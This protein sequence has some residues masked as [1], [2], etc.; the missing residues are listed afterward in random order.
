MMN[1][2]EI[3]TMR[4]KVL[5]ADHHTMLR[6]ALRV[7][8]EREPDIKVIA[9]ESNGAR[10]LQAAR[11]LRP[12]VVVMDVTMPGM[13]G[14]HAVQNLVRLRLGIKFIALATQIDAIHIVQ[15]LNAGANGYVINTSR[16]DEM[17]SAIR[18]VFSGQSY[19]CHQ[20]ARAVT[21]LKRTHAKQEKMSETLAGR[22][23]QVLRLLAQGKG[24]KQIAVALGI[25][26]S[27][28]HVHRRNIMRK[29]GLHKV[30]ELTQYAIRQRIVAV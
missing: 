12:N 1:A 2:A 17:L 26:P 22:E 9:E 11:R 7:V 6:Q 23:R 13:N 29:L 18:M 14:L 20:A 4:I 25:A 8:L 28:V 30:A 19:L 3:A 21:E 16:V 15:M 10:A 5:L 24:S 27:T